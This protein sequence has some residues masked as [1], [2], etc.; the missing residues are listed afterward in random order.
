M[1]D[2]KMNGVLGNMSAAVIGGR[3]YREVLGADTGIMLE[4]GSH[5]V[6]LV[7]RHKDPDVSNRRIIDYEIMRR[8]INE[9]DDL[10]DYNAVE[11]AFSEVINKSKCFKSIIVPFNHFRGEDDKNSVCSYTVAE[12][13]GN[14]YDKYET[15]DMVY[16]KNSFA[17][18][19]RVVMALNLAEA[20]F[21]LEK[22]F[23]G[24][25]TK[26]V[27]EA[28]YVNTDDGDVKIII[29][30]L[31][32]RDIDL[33]ESGDEYLRIVCGD[34]ET[35]DKSDLIR[36]LVY[37]S[38]RLICIENPYD[39]K[40]ALI[41]Y[42]LLTAKAYEA[43][44][45][46]DYGFIFSETK[47]EY[48]E[49]IDKE[50]LQRWNLLPRMIKRAFSAILDNKSGVL[51]VDEWLKYMR[52]LRD[53]LVLVNG[54]FKL[55]DPDASN[56]VSFLAND[57]YSI[58]VWPRKAIYWYHV[59]LLA[60]NVTKEVIAGINTDG[61][62]ENM[63]DEQWVIENKSKVAYLAPGKSIKPEIGM[64][65]EINNTRF[66]VVSGEKAVRTGV[67]AGSPPAYSGLNISQ[68]MAFIELNDE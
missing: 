52:I 58:P 23:D 66:K 46:G 9:K 19:S 59:G 35:L 63:T 40:D 62:I 17:F 48:S 25:L 12:L 2:E 1:V 43:I 39:G 18:H 36:F 8:C 45:S 32:S 68:D 21:A 27:P 55:C 42:P 20:F 26:L 5:D 28:I 51:E 60:D 10:A 7:Q 44:N 65:I 53:C 34:E 57:E 49:Y 37:T 54:Q 31:L 64:D 33:R 29:D 50:A 14:F 16:R 61:F 3:R 56:K 30:R 41:D 22:Y 47:D 4:D 13:P 11:E 15:I 24:Y 38:F 6:V 67:D